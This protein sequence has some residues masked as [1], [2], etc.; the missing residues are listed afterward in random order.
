MTASADLASAGTA[1]ISCRGVQKT[2]RRGKRVTRALASVDLEIGDGE[3]LAVFY[4][5]SFQPFN[6]FV[7]IKLT[8]SHLFS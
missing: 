8:A 7:R 4:G 3:F 5:N 6:V 1:A 2:F